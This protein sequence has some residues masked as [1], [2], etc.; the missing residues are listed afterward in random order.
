MNRLIKVAQTI[1]TKFKCWLAP[2]VFEDNEEKTQTARFFTIVIQG[3]MIFVF[4]SMIASWLTT[5]LIN[6]IISVTTFYAVVLVFSAISVGV[7]R[8]GHVQFAGVTWAVVVWFVLAAG[9]LASNGVNGP[10]YPYFLILILI[11]GL[12]AGIKTSV[13]LAVSGLLFGALMVWLDNIGLMPAPLADQEYITSL[14][15]YVPGFLII[16]VLVYLYQGSINNLIERVRRSETEKREAELFQLKNVELQH[17]IE[18]RKR[19]EADLLKARKNAE[20]ANQAKSTF[21][22][23]M[24]HELRTPLNGILGYT[25][26]LKRDPNATPSQRD[27]L[28]IIQQ[29]GNHLK[30]LINDILDL[31]KIE[32]GKMEL[33]PVQVYLPT[34]LQAI[35]SIIEM[36]GREKEITLVYQPNVNIPNNVLADEKRLRQVLLNLLGNAVKFTDTGQVTLSVSSRADAAETVAGLGSQAGIR[37]RFEVADTGIGM[38]P[39]Q[40]EKIFL[41]FEQAGDLKRRAAGTGLGLPISRQLVELMG[42]TLNVT[43]HPNVGSVFWFEIPLP[44]VNTV[45]LP[46]SAPQ[47]EITGYRGARKKILIVDDQPNNRQVLHT[48]LS[49]L[50]FETALASNGREAL[51]SA[52]AEQPDLILMDLV[53]PEMSGFEA[54]KGLRNDSRKHKPILA[55]SASSALTDQEECRQAGFDGFLAKPIDLPQLFNLLEAHLG[56]TW[57][58]AKPEDTTN[59]TPTIPAHAATP[60]PWIAPPQHELRILYELAQ[61]GNMDRIIEKTR[62]LEAANS[63]YHPFGRRLRQY[64]QSFDDEKIMALIEAEMTDNH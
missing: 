39:E 41:P 51:D 21:L 54:V 63:K 33:Y 52:Q 45:R 10:A 44:V 25:Q 59:N 1:L 60:T 40:I 23:N 35:V 64:A 5:S 4:I 34:F 22:A 48:L 50:G 8:R 11:A 2:P 17:E 46:E 24:S 6:F 47:T 38:T 55:V 29:S 61:F 7:I 30:T 58:Y 13:F 32:A 31:S 43:S 9:S 12:V 57:T 16:P 36:R 14:L 62:Q 37:L 19:V 56:L 3:V 42:G 15:S 20:S 28:D 53:M 18:E 49:S 26:I 27:G